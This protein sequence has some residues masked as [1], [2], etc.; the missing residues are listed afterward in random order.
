MSQGIV[1]RRLRFGDADV[2]LRFAG[3]G[4]AEVLLPA[5][6]HRAVDSGAV[7]AATVD[8]W[9]AGARTGDGVACPWTPD[10][11]GPGGLVR[12]SAVGAVIAVHEGYSGAVTLA[13][14]G[15]RAIL[16][17]VRERRA[18]TWWERA[19]PLRA[20]LFMALGG[21]RR[22]LVHAGAIGDDR[23]GVLLVG[24]RG[25]GKTTAAVAA[26]SHGLGLAGDDYVLLEAD[27]DPCAVSLYSTIAICSSG[28][29][30]EKTVVDVAALPGGSV[31]ATLPV[32][33]LVVP[34]IRGGR[35]RVRRVSPG[36]ALRAWAPTT[37]F[38]LPFDSGTVIA[39]LADVVRKVPCFALDGGDAAGDLADAIDQ[40]LDGAH[41]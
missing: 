24:P 31:R 4:L 25:S 36:L 23:G 40:V 22:H 29:G 10:D 33:A 27:R 37:V 12:G 30:D 7:P 19:A 3:P 34:S 32:R 41:A 14:L 18:V 35:A 5:L 9:E 26:V 2:R 39:S 13:D 11:V 20:A 6:A 21:P 16:H 38:Q 28:G 1:E 17:R 8:V 15:T